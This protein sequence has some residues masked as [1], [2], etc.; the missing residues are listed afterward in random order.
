[1]TTHGVTANGMPAE[2]DWNDGGPLLED[3]HWRDGVTAT[4][5]TEDS[6]GVAGNFVKGVLDRPLP[7]QEASVGVPCEVRKVLNS[8]LKYG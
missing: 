7:G 2:G 1:M 5:V 8:T 3:C 4:G 6:S